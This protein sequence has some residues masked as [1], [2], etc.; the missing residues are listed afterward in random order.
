M[1]KLIF[2]I[3]LSILGLSVNSQARLALMTNFGYSYLIHYKNGATIF[4]I[5]LDQKGAQWCNDI[6]ISEWQQKGPNRIGYHI[7]VDLCGNVTIFD[8]YIKNHEVKEAM[9][10]VV[11]YINKNHI[12]IYGWWAEYDSY[13]REHHSINSQGFKEVY[14]KHYRGTSQN[15]PYNFQSPGNLWF[16]TLPENSFIQYDKYVEHEIL[17]N[18]TPL[19]YM[20]WLIV[21]VEYYISLPVNSSL[22]YGI[23]DKDFCEAGPVGD[24]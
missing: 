12:I 10:D 2:S 7:K 14:A 11:D 15:Y 13:M 1:K 16:F 18:R 24:I 23:T 4:K 19:S 20:D 9:N 3:L 21:K 17:Q 22:D 6:L 5:L 8:K